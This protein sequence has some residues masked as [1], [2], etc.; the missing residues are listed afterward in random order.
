M[1]L[2]GRLFYPGKG[3]SEK[4]YV[5]ALTTDTAVYKGDFVVWDTAATP[6]AITWNSQTLNSDDFVFVKTKATSIAGEQA[7]IVAGPSITSTTTTTAVTSATTGAL[8]MVQTWGI[9]HGRCDATVAAGAQ[10][11][12]GST[13]AGVLADATVSTDA[14]KLVGI[15]LGTNATY[16]RGTATDANRV[17]MM[18]R[19]DF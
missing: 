6:T 14:H 16:T 15:A 10:L 8:V 17:L 2:M 4:R 3:V 7:G 13:D 1:S 12:V 9:T 19:C 5:A 18:V 11:L